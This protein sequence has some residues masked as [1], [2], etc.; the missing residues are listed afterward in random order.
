[1]GSLVIRCVS[2]SI[3]QAYAALVSCHLVTAVANYVFRFAIYRKRLSSSNVSPLLGRSLSKTSGPRL[4]YDG[5][6]IPRQPN[7][8]LLLEDIKQEA[9]DYSNIE[10]LDGLRLFGSP[11][12]TSLDGGSASDAAYSSGRQAV[13]QTLK[14]VKLEDDMYVPH[15]GETPSTMFATLLDS[16]IQG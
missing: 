3:P 9:A 8:G 11:K 1:M 4:L 10:S 2:S 16:G 7:A 5:E 13:R 15:E 12:R 14:P 6:S